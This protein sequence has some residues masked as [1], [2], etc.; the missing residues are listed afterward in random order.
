MLRAAAARIFFLTVPCRAPPP[1]VA[2]LPHRSKGTTHSYFLCSRFLWSPLPLPHHCRI[3]D[4]LIAKVMKRVLKTRQTRTARSVYDANVSGLFNPHPRAALAAVFDFC[5]TYH[6]TIIRPL[7]PSLLAP[8][9]L[10][11]G[12]RPTGEGREGIRAA[13][14]SSSRKDRSPYT[15][16]VR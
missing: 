5:P 2:S 8:P 3:S 16:V 4:R 13:I 1:R 12:A 6:Y 11:D 10:L 14:Q 7:A 9:T 15:S